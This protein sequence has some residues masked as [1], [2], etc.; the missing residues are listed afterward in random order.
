MPEGG[1]SSINAKVD[2][3][4]Y[5]VPSASN[6]EFTS[7]TKMVVYSSAGATSI[8]YVTLGNVVHSNNTTFSSWNDISIVYD[9]TKWNGG[10]GLDCCW[11]C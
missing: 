7:R 4:E 6:N 2:Y 10:F 3:H 1:W 8:P 5:D 9:G 11:F